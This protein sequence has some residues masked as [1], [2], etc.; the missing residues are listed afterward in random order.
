M[1]QVTAFRA[2]SVTKPCSHAG[3]A[4]LSVTGVK[5]VI[6]VCVF[7]KFGHHRPDD[8]HLVDVFGDVRKQ[9]ADRNSAFSVLVKFPKAAE[10]LSFVVELRGFRF[11]GERLTV[12][13]GQPWLWVE[14]IN[15]AD[16]SIHVQKNDAASLRA[17]VRFFRSQRVPGFGGFKL[18]KQTGQCNG[19]KP[20]GS[21]LQRGPASH[22]SW[23]ESSAMGIAHGFA[24]IEGAKEA[25]AENGW[26]F[27]LS[28][29]KP[30][31]QSAR[32]SKIGPIFGRQAC[33]VREFFRKV[34]K[35]TARNTSWELLK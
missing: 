1:R 18:V 2:Q 6:G 10:R 21:G 8:S 9:I 13:F 3:S 26:A 23:S 16:A 4:L 11:H 28:A 33:Q 15:L 14:G 22:R 31:L 19:P 17:E 20:Q 35:L 34:D 12:F 32:C 30:C 29:C 24:D 5:E 25:G 7:R 27:I